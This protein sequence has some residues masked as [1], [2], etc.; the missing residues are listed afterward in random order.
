MICI[1]IYTKKNLFM[2]LLLSGF[3][4]MFFGSLILKEPWFW[5]FS[6]FFKKKIKLVEW[7]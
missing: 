1:Y 3:K 7:M 4:L 6:I 2:R 5:F